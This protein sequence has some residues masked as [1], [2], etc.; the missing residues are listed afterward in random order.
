MS[1]ERTRWITGPRIAVFIVVWQFVVWLLLQMGS[2]VI[3]YE[4]MRVPW[5]ATGIENVRATVVGLLIHELPATFAVML[6]MIS[7]WNE[8]HRRP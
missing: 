1:D 5:D 3:A 4:F 8:T 2:M 6:W 7:I